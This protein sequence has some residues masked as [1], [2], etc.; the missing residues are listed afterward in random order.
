MMEPLGALP[1]Q[2]QSKEGRGGVVGGGL[3]TQSVNV[4]ARPK[5]THTQQRCFFRCS[6][7]DR[8]QLGIEISLLFHN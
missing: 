7:E 5:H 2:L 1:W 3:R 6:S 4:V 8:R